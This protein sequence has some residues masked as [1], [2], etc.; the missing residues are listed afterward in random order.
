LYYI[1]NITSKKEL[2]NDYIT[3]INNSLNMISSYINDLSLIVNTFVENNIA[4]TSIINNEL[5]DIER[6]FIEAGY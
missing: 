2:I 3:S 5:N 1:G 4:D 6:Q